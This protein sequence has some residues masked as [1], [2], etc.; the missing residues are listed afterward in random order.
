MCKIYCAI[1]NFRSSYWYCTLVTRQIMKFSIWT[2]HA[3]FAVH[4]VLPY[5]RN[6]FT[7]PWLSA[8]SNKESTWIVEIYPILNRACHVVCHHETRPIKSIL[9]ILFFSFYYKFHFLESTTKLNKMSIKNS[10]KELSIN[11]IIWQSSNWKGE[12]ISFYLL[13]LLLR[14]LKI[15]MSI[16]KNLEF[17]FI[18]V[19]NMTQEIR[20]VSTMSRF[21]DFFLLL[22]DIEA[23]QF[24]IFRILVEHTKLFPF[25]N[26]SFSEKSRNFFFFSSQ[27]SISSCLVS[28]KIS[29]KKKSNFHHSN[30]TSQRK[31]STTAV[32]ALSRHNLWM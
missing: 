29:A 5:Y 26:F 15:C 18:C 14:I 10:N 17:H 20:T 22:H 19:E 23:F 8:F 4:F 12:E 31:V 11:Q 1:F 25:N 27:P 9:W 21:S 6:L 7:S 28:Y 16:W 30:A 24:G 2:L 3:T 13:F 32:F